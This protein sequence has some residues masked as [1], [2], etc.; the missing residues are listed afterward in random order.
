[1]P[2]FKCGPFIRT[3]RY[4]LGLSD[5]VRRYFGLYLPSAYATR[6]RFH[7]VCVRLGYNITMPWH[8]NFMFGWWDILTISRSSLN[9]KVI[10]MVPTWTGKTGDHFPVREIY[11]DWKGREFYQNTYCL[12]TY[13][14]LS[15]QKKIILEKSGKFYQLVIVKTLQIW[16]HTLHKKEL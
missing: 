5:T 6:Y 13:C 11:Y 2:S 10:D 15:C 1:M 4:C 16:Y 9:M 8:R 3:S 14:H 7:T 12:A